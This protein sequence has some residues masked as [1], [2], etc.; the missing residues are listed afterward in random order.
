[1]PKVTIHEDHG[2]SR[3][4]TPHKH[5]ISHQM[6]H[7]TPGDHNDISRRRLSSLVSHQGKLTAL[8]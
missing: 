2:K 6:Q 4:G 7:L 3:K 5:E 8:H 1:M